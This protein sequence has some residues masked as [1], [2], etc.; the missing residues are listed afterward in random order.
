MTEETETPHPDYVKGFNEG[1]ILSKHMPELAD[2]MPKDLS[3]ERGQGF[4]QGRQQFLSEKEKDKLPFLKND[5]LSG[6]NKQ[7]PVPSKGKDKDAPE[8]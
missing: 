5:R 4:M 7:Q 2:K 1:Y 6:L 8:R 3:G